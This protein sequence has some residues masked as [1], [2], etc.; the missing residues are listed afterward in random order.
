MFSLNPRGGGGSLDALDERRNIVNKFRHVAHTRTVLDRYIT[1]RRRWKWLLYEHTKTEASHSKQAVFRAWSNATGR[2][3]RADA[4]S[5][6]LSAALPFSTWDRF[7]RNYVD[8]GVIPA[9]QVCAPL[10]AAAMSKSFVVARLTDL[11]V[12][13]FHA[14]VRWV[15]YCRC[16][17]FGAAEQRGKIQ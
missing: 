2:R 8:K 13:R 1:K 15:P 16:E 12:H 11:V 3:Y 7:L 9:D 6:T 4:A 14:Q 17:M 10:D 5:L